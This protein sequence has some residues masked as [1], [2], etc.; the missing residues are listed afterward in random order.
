MKEV[1]V[2][3]RDSWEK[4]I[5]EKDF[6]LDI[7]CWSGE[8]LIGLLPQTKNVYGMDID[9]EKASLANPEIK[10]RIKIGDVTKEIPFKEKFD[11]IIFGEVLEHV[12]EDDL[13]L[14]N[15]SASMNKG[16]KLILTT[17]RSVRNF[18]IWD[19]AW[20]RWKFLGGQ[21]HH[22]YT[23]EEL[24]KKLEKNGL[25]IK[26]YYV[27]GDS[28]W[29]LQRWISVFLKFLLKVKKHIFKRGE[30]KGFCDWVVLAEK[31]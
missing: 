9:E 11:W 4:Q 12:D 29:V 24:F 17:P 19:P 3:K 8:K 20:F 15:I 5:S 7:G 25:E 23:K 14:K 26:E 2:G 22:H 6:V 16:G 10:K 30:K 1:K 21:R 28:V 27:T 18:Q 13:A 31:I